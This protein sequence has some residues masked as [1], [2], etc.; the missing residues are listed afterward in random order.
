MTDEIT[1]REVLAGMGAAAAVGVVG[2]LLSDEAFASPKE[3]GKAPFAHALPPLAYPEDALEPVIDKETVKI[4]YYKH[5]DGYIKGLNATLEKIEK[6]RAS[7]DFSLIKALSR[8]MAF[9]GSGVVLHWVYFSTI[10]PKPQPPDAEMTKLLER[11]FGSVETFWKQFDAASRDVEASG[12]AVLAWEPFSKRLVIMQAEKHQNL[13]SWGAM[14]LMVC[15]VWEHAYYLKY[16]NRRA[17]YVENF[18]K[19]VDW[20]KVSERF[21]KYCAR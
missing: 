14:P 2:T 11:D 5:F 17:E 10:G 6:A 4:H 19:I 8:D 12:W 9:H 15:D 13:T 3:A 1:R 16:R 18:K 7:G 21:K 20:S